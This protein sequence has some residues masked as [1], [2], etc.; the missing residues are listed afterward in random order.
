[1]AKTF[2]DLFRIYN[3]ARV[4][5][6]LGDDSPAIQDVFQEFNL[7]DERFVQFGVKHNSSGSTV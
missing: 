4:F 5:Q 3:F 2:E 1:M 6:V 7:I